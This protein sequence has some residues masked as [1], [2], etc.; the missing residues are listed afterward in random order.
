MK[1]VLILHIIIHKHVNSRIFVTK[2]T[3]HELNFN[4]E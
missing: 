3:A 4:V 2:N 1:I